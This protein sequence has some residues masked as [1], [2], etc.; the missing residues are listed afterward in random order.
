MSYIS[1]YVHRNDLE[2]KEFMIC[3][4]EVKLGCHV[5][6]GIEVCLSLLPE[7]VGRYLG[8]FKWWFLCKTHIKGSHC[9][10]NTSLGIF[11]LRYLLLI[12]CVGK[13][14]SVTS[15]PKMIPDLRSVLRERRSRRGRS[16]RVSGKLSTQNHSYPLSLQMGKLDSFIIKNKTNLDESKCWALT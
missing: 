5:P 15:V 10:A 1:R 11:N 14:W 3:T 13:C 4:C 7:V 2:E 12:L 6:L 9:E 8:T 16:G